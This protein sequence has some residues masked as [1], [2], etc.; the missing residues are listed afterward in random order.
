[1]TSMYTRYVDAP[2]STGPTVGAG[3]PRSDRSGVGCPRANR[4]ARP[5]M[6]RGHPSAIGPSQGA[7]APGT[8]GRS[9]GEEELAHVG[10][11]LELDVRLGGPLEGQPR[12]DDGT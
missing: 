10:R 7:P 11:A 5:R 9:E 3:Q 12:V 1:M 6:A 4:R 2:S 8:G